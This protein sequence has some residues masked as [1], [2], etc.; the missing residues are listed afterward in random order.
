MANHV[1]QPP[2]HSESHHI[3]R[4]PA[5]HVWPAPRAFGLLQTGV[6]HGAATLSQFRALGLVNDIGLL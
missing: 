3:I 1:E 4:Q 2:P 5:S 6:S